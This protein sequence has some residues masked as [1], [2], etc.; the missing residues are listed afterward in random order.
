MSSA[1]VIVEMYRSGASIPV[2][3][4]QVGKSRSTVRHHLKKA[5][6]LR[7]RADGVRLAA[8]QGRVGAGHRGKNRQFSEQHRQNIA[9]ARRAWGEANAVGVTL[10]ADG[11]VE[12]TRGEHKGRG[13][14]VVKMEERIGRRLRVDECVHHIDG[15]RA[16]NDDDNLALMTRAA[17]S[18][19]H[20]REDEL[21]GNERE[22]ESNGR[23][24]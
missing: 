12:Y 19:L 6:V 24:C 10:K 8:E 4:E 23:F 7:S 3:A 22:R 14:H 21:A 11:Y 13:V 5:G 2:V 1:D 20:R 9:K 16:N 15:D 17:H 18:R